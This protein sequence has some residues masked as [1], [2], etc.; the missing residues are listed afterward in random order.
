MKEIKS[1]KKIET[2]S[3]RFKRLA[4][5]R[6]RKAIHYIDLVSNL[7]NKN[8][9]DYSESDVKKIKDS[10]SVSIRKLNSSFDSAKEKDTFKL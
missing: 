4:E 6:V 5:H 8:A 7:S 3:Q 9:Y 1:N 10:L 2:K